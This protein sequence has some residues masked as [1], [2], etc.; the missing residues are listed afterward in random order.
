FEEFF[1]WNALH[2]DAALRGCSTVSGLRRH[3]VW[4]TGRV[5]D[6][7]SRGACEVQ[8]CAGRDRA[9]VLPCA[10]ARSSAIEKLLTASSLH[11]GSMCVAG[12]CGTLDERSKRRG[13]RLLRLWAKCPCR[14]A[15][16]AAHLGQSELP[17][18]LLVT[19]L[20]VLRAGQRGEKRH[21]VIDL[22]LRQR[23]WLHVLVEPGVRD[24]I[25]LVVVIHYIPQ[26]FHRP[27]VEVGPGHEDISQ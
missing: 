9:P 2:W 11:L 12:F 18:I 7:D 4:R 22:G 27:V 8:H 26:C 1:R 24:S 3:M 19:D 5:A 25:T 15:L 21:H 23:Q 20:L 13:R 10:A 14:V 6:R 16:W 17:R